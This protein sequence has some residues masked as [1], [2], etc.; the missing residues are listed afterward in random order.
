MNFK[1]R[2]KVGQKSLCAVFNKDRARAEA[3]AAAAVAVAAVMAV[4][5]AGASGY[6]GLKGVPA[7]DGNS[8]TES[9]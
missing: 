8:L 2:P 3:S 1:E 5:D 9:G 4:L 6:K 7:F